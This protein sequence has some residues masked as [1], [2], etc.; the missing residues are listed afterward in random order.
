MEDVGDLGLDEAG[1]QPLQKS[2]CFYFR[3]LFCSLTQ[4]PLFFSSSPGQ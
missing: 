1:L 3:F 4:E 2:G